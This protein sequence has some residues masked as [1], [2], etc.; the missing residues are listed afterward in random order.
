[1]FRLALLRHA[2]AA[3]PS[4]GGDHAR[5]L[6]QRGRQ[7][8]PRLGAFMAEQ[9]ILP[10]LALVSDSRRTRETFDLV[11]PAFAQMPSLRLVPRIYEASAETLLAIVQAAPGSAGVLL[12]IGH[13]PGLAELAQRLTGFGDRYAASRMR[14]KFPTCGL[15]VLDFDV[16]TWAEVDVRAGRLDCFVT[17]AQLGGEDD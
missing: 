13:N 8:A 12:L 1:M 11:G 17:P 16:A 14:I 10:D 7:D 2:K 4:G 15:A 6:A 9:G 3:A 5:P